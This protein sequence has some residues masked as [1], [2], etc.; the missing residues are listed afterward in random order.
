MTEVG[1]DTQP[2]MCYPTKE[3]YA[4][5]KKR[6]N[7]FDMTTSEYMQAMIEAGQKKFEVSVEAEEPNQEIREERNELMDQLERAEE[8][9]EDLH[10][11][12]QYTEQSAVLQYVEENPGASFDEILDHLKETL[13]GRLNRLLDELEGSELRVTEDRYHRHTADSLL[14]DDYGPN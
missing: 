5:W 13:P 4:R 6:A 8:R 9:I 3:Q 1:D 12:R 10:R 11:S 7:E 14:E 2:A